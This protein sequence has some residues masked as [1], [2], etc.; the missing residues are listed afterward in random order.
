MA[1]K[2]EKNSFAK[3]V[4]WPIFKKN[5]FPKEFFSKIWLKVGEH[6]YINILT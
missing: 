3:I 5:T 1:A 6:E 4:T 2:K